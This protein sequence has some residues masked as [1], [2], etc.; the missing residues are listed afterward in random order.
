[1]QRA[2]P[3]LCWKQRN[4]IPAS[5]SFGFCYIDND[6]NLGYLSNLRFENQASA[7]G[8]YYFFLNHSLPGRLHN[9]T[10]IELTFLS[11][12]YFFSFFL[13]FF[14]FF[15]GLHQRHVEVLRLGVQSEPQLLAYATATAMPDLSHVCDLHHSS[16]QCWISY[17]LSEAR[18]Q[19]CIL[20]D[21]SQICFCWAMTGTPFSM[22]LK[23]LII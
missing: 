9:I 17:P 23:P 20:M 1:M 4:N 5:H 12:I 14:F 2:Y 22:F 18:D 11:C 19:T 15:L 8:T 16:W 10:Y 6:G 7:K 13:S 21:A 3:Q